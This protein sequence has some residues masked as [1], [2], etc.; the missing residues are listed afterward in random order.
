M[1]SKQE[2]NSP[3]FIHS[4]FRSGS[5][6]VFN[7][8]RR[9]DEYY[10]CYQEPT[11]EVAFFSKNNR[12][13]LLL[14][15]DEMQAVMRHADLDSNYFQELYETWN[16]WKELIKEQ[17]V[18]D[19]YFDN[20]TTNEIGLSY[21]SAL[22]NAAKARPVLQECRTSGR[23]MAIKEALGGFHIYL[24]RN[25]WDQWWS[26][27]VSPYF[28]VASQLIIHSSKSPFSVKKLCAELALPK[29]GG[30]DIAQAFVF[31]YNTPL[32]SEQS[33]LIFYILWCLGL[34]SGIEHSDLLLSIDHLSESGSYRKN[35]SAEL[36][37]KAHING[38]D[39]SDCRVPQSVYT[40]RDILFLK[41]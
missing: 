11:H 22:I 24:W 33:Y 35:I 8:F 5:T 1:N 14:D 41:V 15:K 37:E 3:I 40:K 34:R 32:T 2:H 36:M 31:Y 39:F 6:Y 18:Y 38:V 13:N 4:L 19:A 20:N 12:D 30:N 17:V 29:Y 23:I 16:D 28:D 10:W 9:S 27:K 21:W 26:Y 25:P 7:V